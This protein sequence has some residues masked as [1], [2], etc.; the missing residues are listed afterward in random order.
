MKEKLKTILKLQN[1][2]YEISGAIFTFMKL[3]A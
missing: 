3:V 1:T 2:T